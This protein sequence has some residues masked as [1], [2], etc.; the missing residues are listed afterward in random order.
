M[1][2]IMPVSRCCHRGDGPIMHCKSSGGGAGSNAA[3]L[4]RG[5][6]PPVLHSMLRPGGEMLLKK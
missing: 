5:G 6:M 1:S 4:P 2:T 3:C